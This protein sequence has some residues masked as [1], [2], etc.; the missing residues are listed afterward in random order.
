MIFCGDTLFPKPY[1]SPIYCEHSR[2]WTEPKFVNFE[3]SINL[4]PSK[5]L[6]KGIALQSH[7]SVIDFFKSINVIGVSL[8]NN[9]FFDF[10]ISI[11]SQ[12]NELKRNGIEAVGAGE[13][14]ESASQPFISENENIVVLTFGWNVIRCKYATYLSAGVNPLEYG[15]VEKQVV[16][17]R[18]LHPSK[19]LIVFFH[20]N[21]EFEQYPQPADRE[22]SHHLIDLGVDAI[23]GHHAHIPQGF[24]FYKTKPIFFGL[25]NF[26]FPNG[27]Y[28]D[29]ELTFPESAT[30]GLS[31][32]IKEDAVMAYITQLIDN[33][34]VKVL[35]IGHP[36][37]IKLLKALSPFQGMSNRDYISFFQKN[38]KK[39]KALPIY[40]SYKQKLSN[41]F[42]DKLV[43]YR[44]I[45]ID[46]LSKAKNSL[47]QKRKK[48][49]S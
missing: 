17:Y 28:S 22:F 7:P 36:S 5:K 47:H 30:I 6:T 10:S 37:E 11:N 39:R 21:Y 2:F 15:W 26:Y 40:R 4:G 13:N 18:Q 25:G 14:L 8:A 34:H 41:A 46:I 19:K 16:K 31:V 32:E 48:K 23:L 3:S 20:W 29:H 24:E 43:M 42:Y 45:P 35:E 33:S 49:R 9:H 38:R 27:Y 12:K 44:Q 1:H